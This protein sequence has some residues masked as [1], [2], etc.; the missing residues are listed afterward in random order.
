M[1]PRGMGQASGA[2]P[3]DAA[4]D[5]YDAGYIQPWGSEQ[6]A[7]FKQ[8]QA[9]AAA[10]FEKAMAASEAVD[11]NPT[12]QGGTGWE[13]QDKWNASYSMASNATGVPGNMIKAIQALETGRADYTGQENCEVRPEAG[14][15]ALNSGIYKATADAYGL[16]YERIRDDPAYAIEAIG[17]V[18]GEIANDDAG[19]WG[20]T[21]GKSVL[22]EG[23]WLGV[24]AVYHGGNINGTFVDENGTSSSQYMDDITMYLEQLGGVEGEL[25]E[26]GYIPPGETFTKLAPDQP[27]DDYSPVY[28]DGSVQASA[29]T[30]AVQDVSLIWG[31]T[32]AEVVSEMGDTDG[33]PNDDPNYYDFAK[34]L[35]YEGNPGVDYAMP[36]GTKIYA[37]IEGKVVNLGGEFYKDTEG[38]GDV[39]IQASNGDIII[40]GN[41]RTA[42]LALG[43]EIKMGDLIGTSGQATVDP[44]S[45]RLHMEVRVLQPDGSYKV[46]NPE[47]Y[48]TGTASEASGGTASI[49]EGTT[50]NVTSD[51]MGQQ[52]ADLADNYL[53]VEYV[54]GSIPRAG[55]DPYETG[56]DCSGFVSYI[57]D[58]L[59]ISSNQDP[60][61]IPNGSHYQAEW[62]MD[63]GKW[64][65]GNDVSQLQPGDVIFLDTGA[66][67]GGGQ[68]EVSY[69]ASR[70]THVGIYL[71]DGKMISAMQECG[72]GLTNGVNCGTG[73]VDLSES[74]WHDSMIGSATM[75]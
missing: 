23:G 9:T 1:S 71:G 52:I 45:A 39:R 54:W 43:Q 51:P 30:L 60:K 42:D 63:N 27:P 15:L 61:G 10:D 22:D 28:T 57:A 66:N 5:V 73:T 74:Y 72:P 59:G 26:S 3:G 19:Q 36:A 31:G 56:W 7:L 18:L 20:G 64:R 46:A 69:A 33:A 25:E 53:N 11:Q 16:D 2:L 8:R 50:R 40:L 44:E 35:G 62:A 24:A 55:A 48:L 47:E 75:F 41:M 14:C 17:T 32:E 38:I 65:P 13:V 67:G 70:A 29:K 12:A 58:T 21:P 6:D 4:W 37:P 49:P 34:D 68:N